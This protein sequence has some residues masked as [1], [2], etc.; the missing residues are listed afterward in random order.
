MYFVY[1][2][3]CKDNSLYTGITTNIS[4]RLKE[5]S[6]KDEKCAK[7]TLRH[8]VVKLERL[9]QTD[10]RSLASKLEYY[11][12]RLNK[13]QKEELIV[14]ND[15]FEILFSNKLECEKYIN[16]STDIII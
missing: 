3:R 7:Y 4:R 10:N 15:I 8:E 1:I 14:N 5:H 9:W 6:L 12:K 11:I 16:I 13:N 2:L